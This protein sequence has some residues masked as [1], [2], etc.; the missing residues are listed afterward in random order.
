MAGQR[1]AVQI[2]NPNT[3][4]TIIPNKNFAIA[5]RTK[6]L[7]ACLIYKSRSLAFYKMTVFNQKRSE[8]VSNAVGIEKNTLKSENGLKKQ[9]CCNTF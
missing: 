3:C 7:E 9:I 2:V 4:N 5:I 6:S 8:L 1:R